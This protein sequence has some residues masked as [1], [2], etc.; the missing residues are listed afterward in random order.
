MGCA[1]RSRGAPAPEGLIQ[2]LLQSV[3][4]EEKSKNQLEAHVL[5]VLHQNA[6]V[7]G[8]PRPVAVNVTAVE[9]LH[10]H[11]V[12]CGTGE[13]LVNVSYTAVLEG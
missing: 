1:N 7:S 10:G 12:A 8:R 9:V 11:G 13:K 4:L 6:S 5:C 2:L 3:L